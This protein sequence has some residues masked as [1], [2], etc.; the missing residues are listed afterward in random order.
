MGHIFELMSET[1][2]PVHMTLS[3]LCGSNFDR[4]YFLKT[5]VTDC[6]Q[7]AESP[8]RRHLLPQLE[9]ARSARRKAMVSRQ[10]RC[11]VWR[12]P[13]VLIS[14]KERGVVYCASC[15]KLTGPSFVGFWN[16]RYSAEHRLCGLGLMLAGCMKLFFD[17]NLTQI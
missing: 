15:H 9:Q 3:A 2:V 1:L 8:L 10:Q 11:V 14:R 4:V 5:F 13:S 7:C 6:G 16:H 17:L 12:F